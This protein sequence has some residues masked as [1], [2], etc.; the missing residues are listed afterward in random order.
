MTKLN[1][2]NGVINALMKHVNCFVKACHFH[3]LKLPINLYADE[4]WSWQTA[5]S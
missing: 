2:Y 1:V 3:D 4:D 5:K